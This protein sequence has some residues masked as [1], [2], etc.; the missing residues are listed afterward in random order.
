M[1]NFPLILAP[2]AGVSDWIFRRICLSC[3]ATAT[4]TEM[5]SAKAMHFRDQKTA[6]LGYLAEGEETTAIQIFGREP[7]IIAEAVA[8]LSRGEY[9]GHK[10]VVRPASIDIN[11]GCPVRKI[12]SGGQGS[13]LMREPTLVG[14]IVQAAV[15]AS[16]M[17][18]TVKIRAG[19]DSE[20][21]NAVEIA[22]IAEAAGAAQIAVH[23]RTREQMYTGD[24][25][26]GIIRDVKQAV[27]VPVIGNGGVFS[28]ADAVKMRDETGVDGIMLARGAMG[29]PWL[30]AEVAAALDGRGY[31][32]PT[33]AEVVAM[34]KLHLGML[35]D[36][37]GAHAVQV[38]RKHMAWYIRGTRNAAA[39]RHKINTTPDVDAMMAVLG[40][41]E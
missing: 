21:R 5:I 25:D 23:G 12:V 1:S 14:E 16:A 40:E 3:G 24:A 33:T 6:E 11:M 7:E 37:L 2:M 32:P 27:S 18:I 28:A 38:A 39:L 13:A 20:S 29:N 36:A 15:A 9:D 10:S 26:H 17:P 30:F 8:I 41:V 35:V 31:T 22:K 34:A 4:V 19:W